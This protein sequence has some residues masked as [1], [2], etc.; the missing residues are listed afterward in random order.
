MSGENWYSL[1]QPDDVDSPALLVYPDRVMKN[2]STAIEMTG[3]V[4]RLRPHIKTNKS[5]D[6]TALLIAAGVTKFKCATIAECELLGLAGAKDVLLAYQPIGPKIRR[7]AEIIRKYSSTTYSC[8]IDNEDAAHAM[9]RYFD[10]SGLNV[11]VFVDLNVGQGRTGIEAG[12][13]AALLYRVA[14]TIPGINP[15]G[16]HAYDG[17]VRHRDFSLRKQECDAC[18][19]LVENTRDAI[20]KAGQAVPLIVAGGSPSFS[21][22]CRRGNCECSPGTFIY[23][24][25]GYCDLCPEQDF[26]P[27]ALVLSRIISIPGPT[28][29]CLDLG[30]KAVA[31]ENEIT[32]RV[33]FLNAPGLR[34]I[35]QSEEHL[36]LETAGNHEFKVG[37]ILYGM[38]V[39]ICP[40]VAL[41]ERAFVVRDGQ[42]EGEWRNTARDRKIT[43]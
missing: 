9:G 1:L 29:I 10:A 21:V 20:V 5:P 4:S 27:A 23:W 25:K 32:R 16:L 35:S 39:H 24:D 30:H 13:P 28:T 36:V 31:A 11:P 8:L 18:F 34:A 41:Y 15:V 6:A 38:P 7:F 43:I 17:H 42:V 37:D 14:E 3:D 19:A 40:T 12:L 22:H 26:L 33:Y 2:I